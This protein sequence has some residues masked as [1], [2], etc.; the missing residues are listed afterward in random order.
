[1]NKLK[2]E[3]KMKAKISNRRF[4]SLYASSRR[5]F[6][7]IEVLI[8]SSIM[9]GI[10]VATL[11]LYTKSNKVSVD[12][13]QFADIQH[14][15]RAAMYFLSRDIKSIGAGLPLQFSHAFLEGDNNDSSGG[16]PVYPDRLTFLGNSDPLRL[17]IQSFDPGSNTVTFEPNQFDMYPYTATS[18]PADTL[19]YINRLII[20]FP[21]PELNVQKG[22]VGKITSV[23]FVTNQIVFDRVNG[24]V[25]KDLNLNP[26]GDPDDY[27]GGTVTF[28]ELKTYWLDVDGSYPGGHVGVDGYLGEPGVMYVSQ[29]NPISDSY[30]HLAL[31]LNIEDLQFQYHGD[32]DADQQLDDNNSDTI[33]DVNDFLNWG[34]GGDK[35]F[36]WNDDEVSA[37]IRSVRFLILGKTANPYIGFSGTPSDAMRYIYGKPAIADSP[38]GDEMDKHRRFLLE[39]TAQ[40]RNMSLSLYN[41]GTN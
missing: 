26:G 10:I 1:M 12:Q 39:S 2:R 7:V 34:D 36:N 38:A 29:W 5:G 19:G 33:I 11:S 3:E 9:L 20:V 15:V 13:Q 21:N 37:G 40:I 25:P 23:N 35:S 24:K 30:E 6:T 18:Y 32:M 22:E 16:P 17:I 31:A 41:S 27:I 4:S 14:N 28:I 8:G